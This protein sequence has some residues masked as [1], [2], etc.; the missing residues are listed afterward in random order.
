MAADKSSYALYVEKLI[1]ML[2]EV[3]KE[4]KKHGLR[5]LMQQ[6]IRKHEIILSVL[7]WEN[8]CP[9]IPM[10]YHCRHLLII[11]AMLGMLG[12]GENICG[13]LFM[14]E[15]LPLGLLLQEDMAKLISV[16]QRQDAADGTQTTE[17][18]VILTA[19]S[20]SFV[21]REHEMRPSGTC[22]HLNYHRRWKI[23]LILRNLNK[24]QGINTKK[25]LFFMGKQGILAGTL[26]RKF[27]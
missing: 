5:C 8:G 6:E 20:F 1:Q 18:L 7:A 19:C 14:M 21:V 10:G 27:V 23:L 9:N 15:L 25:I 3:N 13:W 17:P 4:T 24:K 11:K 2:I 26:H 22:H 12:G 16:S